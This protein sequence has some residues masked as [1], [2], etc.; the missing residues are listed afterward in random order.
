MQVIKQGNGLRRLRE[1]RLLT[2]AELAAALGARQ[3]S[4]SAWETGES[5][6]SM[7][8]MRKLCQVLGVETDE[9]LGALNDIRPSVYLSL[10]EYQQGAWT[11]E[12]LANRARAAMPGAGHG[13]V[14]YDAISAAPDNDAALRQAHLF[15]QVYVRHPGGAEFPVR[16]PL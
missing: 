8:S 2:Q 14:A 10:D 13:A 11:P 3:A 7:A 16:I 1:R 15:V 6:P 5:R 4:V 12:E 9:L